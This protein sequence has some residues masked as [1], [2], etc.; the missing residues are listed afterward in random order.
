MAE[1][2]LHS[3]RPGCAPDGNG[4]GWLDRFN[5]AALADSAAFYSYTPPSDYVL[6]DNHLTFTSPAACPYPENNR[7]H[8]D[9]FPAGGRRAVVVLPQWNA[10][11]GRT[12]LGLCRLLNRFGI[13]ALRMTLAYHDRR[14]PPPL[15]RADYHVSS[16]IGRTIHAGRQSV[17]DARSCLDWLAASGYDHLGILGTSLGSCIAF[18][19]AAHDT[20]VSAAVYNHVS[21]HFGDVVWTGLSTGH[22]RVGLEGAVTRD[23]LRRH[24]RM[25]SPA[26]F[27]PRIEGRT[28]PSLLIWAKYDSTF[29]PEF[30]KQVLAEKCVRATFPTAFSRCRAAI[31]PPAVSR[32]TSWMASPC[33]DFSPG[34]STPDNKPATFQGI[35]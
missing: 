4:R 34:I 11:R 8:A 10:R 15:T 19:T 35:S 23:E 9:F 5:A 26:T 29:L 22:I 32:S 20:R 24:W 14:M 1:Q 2:Y 16:N 27:F 13:T 28:H 18:I 33:A 3:R 12:R 7:V 25:I 6:K 31:T 21:M 17:L 30:S